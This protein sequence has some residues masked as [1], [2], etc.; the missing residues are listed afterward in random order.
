MA[1]PRYEYFE[2]NFKW[3]V[4]QSAETDCGFPVLKGC[5]IVPK[6][7][8][9]FT[10]ARRKLWKGGFVH[11]FLDDYLFD[12]NR[13]IWSS[14]DRYRTMLSQYAGV[15]A[16]DFSVYSDFDRIPQM[17]NVYRSRLVAR[18]FELWGLNVIPTVT[19]GDA[20]TFDFCFKGI[21]RHTVLAVSTVGVMKSR[22]T[23]KAF[24]AG[25]A[26]MCECLSPS[27]AVLYGSARGLE[28]GGCP[29][30]CYSNNTYDW[31]HL[32]NYDATVSRFTKEVL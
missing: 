31:T 27:L 24:E 15:L 2:K 16:P 18:E 26:R 28:L 30:K 12:G 32:H 6:C 17:W 23:R 25:F 9:Q 8:V 10:E 29:I 4:R 21:P 20:S 13:G 1:T 19:W 3:S 5:G 14:T 22:E 11:F 7:L